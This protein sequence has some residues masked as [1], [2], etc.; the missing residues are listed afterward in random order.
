ML[1]IINK[2]G[3]GSESRKLRVEVAAESFAEK[4][5][6]EVPNL[7]GTVSNLFVAQVRKTRKL[8]AAKQRR[9]T[10]RAKGRQDLS[11]R[12]NPLTLLPGLKPAGNYENR[13]FVKGSAYCLNGNLQIG[14]CSKESSP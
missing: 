6:R 5:S 7:W 3:S 14:P 8:E 2:S 1:V 13:V 4:V 10:A 12:E 11:P 9:R